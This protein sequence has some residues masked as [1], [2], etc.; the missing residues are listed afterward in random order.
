MTREIDLSGFVPV[1]KRE[2]MSS[3]GCEVRFYKQ[4]V[5]RITTE[6][7]R[8]LAG[9]TR[10][11]AL[12]EPGRRRFVILP[13]DDN[14]LDAYVLRPVPMTTQLSLISR[15]L[16]RAI[17]PVLRA[18]P[19]TPLPD[20]PGLLVDLDEYESRRVDLVVRATRMGLDKEFAEV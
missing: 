19:A 16:M 13:A 5:M 20:R 12:I 7:V 2:R 10:A 6:A 11:H 18:Y 1:M 17:K 15:P 4:G 14:A 9:A 3:V 8:M